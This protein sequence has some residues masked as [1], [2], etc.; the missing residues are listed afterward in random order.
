MMRILSF[1]IGLGILL[2]LASS[3]AAMRLTSEY[4]HGII[5]WRIFNPDDGVRLIGFAEGTLA[6]GQVVERTHPAGRYQLEIREGGLTGRLLA[7]GHGV[8]YPDS[9]D[10][11]FTSS[12][13]LRRAQR[14]TLRVTGEIEVQY[15]LG[16]RLV[17][18]PFSA[19]LYMYGSPESLR[20]T[21]DPLRIVRDVTTYV[22]PGFGTFS[23][24]TGALS[25]PGT[26][27]VLG[28]A[29]QIVFTTSSASS[30]RLYSGTGTPLDP[31]T[32]TMVLVGAGSVLGIEFFVKVSARLSG[33]AR[34]A[35][36]RALYRERM[37]GPPH[38]A[39]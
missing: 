16:A 35:R 27:T 38:H 7:G 31:M 32:R 9:D 10:L 17:R 15:P 13:K 29:T 6:S 4:P 24:G 14:T 25:L 36:T 5:Y 33:A 20:V 2:L 23:P 39:P 30:G 11:I 22:V 1:L 8:I 12:G 34:D 21:M 26:V 19:K 37:P 18:E 3:A 28:S